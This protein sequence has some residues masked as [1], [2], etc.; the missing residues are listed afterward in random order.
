MDL[1]II[2]KTCDSNSLS[3]ANRFCGESKLNIIKKCL[4]SIVLSAGQSGRRVKITIVDD[5]SSNECIDALKYILDASFLEHTIIQREKNSVYEAT[6]QT[7]Q[8]ARDSDATLIYCVED[9]YLHEP[10]C[11]E[12][13]LD[14][15]EYAF[16]QLNKTKDIVLTPFDDPDNYKIRYLEKSHVVLGN[17]RHWRTNTHTSCTFM[18][19]PSIIR[20]MWSSFEE[21]AKTLAPNRGSHTAI[22]Y[23]W[24]LPTVQLFSPIPSTAFHMHDEARADK[25]VAWKAL[26]DHVPYDI[27]STT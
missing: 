1:E 16:N 20:E 13:M 15:Y 12:E 4:N 27:R 3:T 8:I 17:R 5:A 11:I 24:N 22:D 18:T 23:V 10:T 25:I 6:L 7:F 9:D 2:V 26:W 21:Y 14:F 19:S